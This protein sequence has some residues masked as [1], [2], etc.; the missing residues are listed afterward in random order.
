M[1]CPLADALAG[2]RED[3]AFAVD[4]AE[5]AVLVIGIVCFKQARDVRGRMTLRQHVEHERIDAPQIERL[6]FADADVRPQAFAAPSARERERRR[7]N[8]EASA[9]RASRDDRIGHG[10]SFWRSLSMSA[11]SIAGSALRGWRARSS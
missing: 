4:D 9:V 6:R 5:L 1:A 8:A 11:N 10:A 7:R 3:R 2:V